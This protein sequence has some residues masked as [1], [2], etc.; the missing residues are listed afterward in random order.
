ME[1]GDVIE[2]GTPIFHFFDIIN[3]G[4]KVYVKLMPEAAHLFAQIFDGLGFTIFA[5]KSM[6]AIPS[7]S[8]KNLY[9]LFGDGKHVYGWNATR[10]PA[11]Q[12]KIW[13]LNKFIDFVRDKRYCLM[14][15]FS[16]D[17]RSLNMSRITSIMS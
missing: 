7:P 15:T 5:L 3:D 6:V 8:A 13:T 2:K 16:A 17:R 11:W 4:E 12:E 10:S 1:N 9:H 14:D